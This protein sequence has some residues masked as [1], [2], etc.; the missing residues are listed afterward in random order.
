MPERL[1]KILAQN[2]CGSRRDCEELIRQGRV[3]VDGKIVDELGLH[4]DAETQSIKVD[5]ER[6]KI[7][8]PCYF[9]LNKPPGVICTMADDPKITRAVDFAPKGAGRVHTIGRLDKES[10]GLIILTND[11][12]LTERLTHPRHDMPKTYH[13]TVDG[14][15]SAVAITKLRKGVWLSEG[16]ATASSVSVIRHT[17]YASLLEIELREGKNREIRRILARV[18]YKVKALKRVAIGPIRIAG[19]PTGKIRVLTPGEIA[20]L[21][22]AVGQGE[23]G[24]FGERSDKIARGRAAILDAERAEGKGE[25]ARPRAGFS[26]A[27]LRKGPV[28]AQAGAAGKAG[29]AAK[30]GAGTGASAKASAAKATPAKE[31]AGKAGGGAKE[32]IL[33]QK[34]KADAARRAFEEELLDESD[35]LEVAE[36]ASPAA[37]EASPKLSKRDLPSF[38]PIRIVTGKQGLVPLKA[39]KPAQ[40]SAG[41]KAAGGGKAA[42]SRGR[43]LGGPGSP[44]KPGKSA[45][46][47]KAPKAPS[48]APAGPAPVYPATPV[49]KPRYEPDEDGVIV[50]RRPGARA[51]APEQVLGDDDEE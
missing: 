2:G 30:A 41:A 46:P 31:S 24:A 15:I 10:E 29:A 28:S 6:L 12:D 19:L 4:I 18:G 40:G 9:L 33:S 32:K 22:E 25:A 47:D 48:R 39:A 36:V 3:A 49:A 44:G 42:A 16:K 43:P 34:A 51:T 20:L 1:Q 21:F 35:D 27:G 5:G 17:P 45:G 38:E 14:A 11:G 8:D 23:K 26:K 50:V 7:V 37:P 13:V